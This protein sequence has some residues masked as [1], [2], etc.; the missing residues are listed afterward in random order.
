MEDDKQRV[1]VLR[2]LIEKLERES[3]SL[4]R[5]SEATCELLGARI[6]ELEEQ[7]QESSRQEEFLVE[8]LGFWHQKYSDLEES[9]QAE[10]QR[11]LDRIRQNNASN[12]SLLITQSYLYQTIANK[13]A[14]ID[15]LEYRLNLYASY[16]D[17]G[18]LSEPDKKTK[19][20]NPSDDPAPTWLTLKKP[21]DWYGI[22]LECSRPSEDARSAL[23][24]FSDASDDGF[25]DQ[26]SSEPQSAESSYRF[27]S[28]Q[29]HRSESANL[30]DEDLKS[31]EELDSAHSESDMVQGRNKEQ[32]G[33]EDVEKLKAE[34]EMLRL[35]IQVLEDK[36]RA[37]KERERKRGKLYDEFLRRAPKIQHEGWLTNKVRKAYAACQKIVDAL[38]LGD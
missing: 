23:Q 27:Y 15:G 3:L 1:E 9:K 22:A 29:S 25:L 6:E 12:L 33:P 31:N 38:E 36:D 30:Q 2:R 14:R 8:R 4:V 7:A 13:D 28:R 32:E 5:Q 37:Y 21:E 34:V 18:T 19:E 26:Q 24:S 20:P 10:K 35:Q 17:G 11:L 16:K